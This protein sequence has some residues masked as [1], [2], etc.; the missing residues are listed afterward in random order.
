M[1]IIILAA[2]YAT[3][4]YPLTLDTPKC[5]LPVS[6]KSI[7][8]RLLQKIAAI[9]EA[10]SV[11]IV[12]NA[13]FF[14]KINAWKD[15]SQ[16]KLFTKIV[17]DGTLSNETRR[18]AIADWDLAMEEAGRKSDVLLLAGDNLFESDLDGFIE[19]CRSKKGFVC[20]GLHDIKRRQLAAKKY[21][22]LHIDA[23]GEVLS[24]EE[25]PDEPKSSLVG[26]GVYYFPKTMLSRV[27]EY[28]KEKENKDAP[29][30]FIRWLVGRERIFGFL[31]PGMWYDIGDLRAL[32]NAN[33][34]FEKNLNKKG[35]NL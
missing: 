15:S 26:M 30:H 22:V 5:L 35:L 34:L 7:L 20:V 18:G 17:N 11:W 24:F 1:K 27:K 8:D 6:G 4:L 28:L 31:F 2:G 32:E 19:F 23:K 33:R 12:T 14:E 3:R 10:E 13:K 16:P 9:K 21:G 29:G 25:K